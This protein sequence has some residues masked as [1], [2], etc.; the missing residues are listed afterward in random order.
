MFLL[1]KERAL[2][3]ELERIEAYQK[4]HPGVGWQSAKDAVKAGLR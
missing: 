4:N 2:G 1:D 3:V